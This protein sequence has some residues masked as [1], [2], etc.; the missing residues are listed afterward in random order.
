MVF[1]VKMS[2]SISDDEKP[3]SEL[4]FPGCIDIAVERFLTWSGYSEYRDEDLLKMG[5][6]KIGHRKRI[7][8]WLDTSFGGPRIPLND[9]KSIKSVNDKKAISAVFVN[10][11]AESVDLIHLVSNE[12]RNSASGS[13]GDDESNG[14]FSELAVIPDCNDAYSGYSGYSTSSTDQRR[15]GSWFE[16]YVLNGGNSDECLDDGKEQELHDPCFMSEPRAYYLIGATDQG[17]SFQKMLDPTK[18][19]FYEHFG[20]PAGCRQIELVGH[21]YPEPDFDRDTGELQYL[22]L[23]AGKNRN[24]IHVE[25]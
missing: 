9:K 6:D 21:E 22:R 25:Y 12:S 24:L 23:E 13:D 14:K 8:S 7:I 11:T 18:M 4:I 2:A 1:S 19:K 15:F 10:D 5:I 17:F 3:V 16:N 20:Y